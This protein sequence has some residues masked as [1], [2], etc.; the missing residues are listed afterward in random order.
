MR[1]EQL[2][3]WLQ[4]AWKAGAEDNIEATKTEMEVKMETAVETE[5]TA[6][7]PLVLSH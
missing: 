4:E 5:M 3:K 2:Q 7:G 1:S 6:M